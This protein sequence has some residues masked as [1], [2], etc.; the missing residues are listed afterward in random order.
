MKALVVV[1]HGSRRD[2]SNKEVEQLGHE[3][4]KRLESQYPL[5]STGFLELAEPLIPEAIIE[6]I[7]Q[8]ATEVN[9]LPYFLSAGRHVQEDVPHEVKTVQDAYPHINIRLLSYIG[10]LPQL[11]DLMCHYAESEIT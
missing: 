10:S 8:G 4:A 7:K 11:L 2:A 3:M 6:C 5:V 9:V 1:A